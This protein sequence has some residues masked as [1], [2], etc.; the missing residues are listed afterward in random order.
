MVDGTV[1]GDSGDEGNGD[2]RDAGS[3]LACYRDRWRWDKVTWG[4]HCLNCL[5]TCPYRVY[6]RDGTILFEEPAAELPVIEAGVP[7]MNPLSCQKGSAWSR[8]LSGKDRILTPLRRVGER[9][10]GEWEEVSWDDALTEIAEAIVEAIDIEGPESV[11]F[12]ETVEGGLLTQAPVTRFAG[13]LG[14]VTLDANGLV[15]DFPTGQHIT[16][17]KFSCASTVDD[18]FHSDVILAW[19]SNPA[20]T[21]IPYF[22]YIPEARYSGAQV[23]AISPDYTPTAA[24]ADMHVP[25]RAGTDAAFALA[26]CKVVIDEG[27]ADL[28]FVRSQTDLAL[29]VETG[30]RT[31]LRGPEIDPN[32]PEDRFWF[33]DAAA[34][35][36]KAPRDTLKLDGLAPELEGRWKVGLSDGT[37]VEVTTVYELLRERL[38]GYEPEAATEMC[39]VAPDVIRDLARRIAKGRTKILEGFN[40]CKYY[41]GDL[42]ERSMCLLLAL[43]GNWGRP[44]TGIQGLA[45]A[46][47]DG[48]LIFA[49]K[50]RPGLE[51]TIGILDGVDGAME[52]FREQDPEASDEIVG[53]QLLQMAVVGGT[54]TPPVFFNYHHAG[55]DDAWNRMEWSDPSMEKTFGEYL[56]EA[57]SRGWW[58]GLTRPGSDTDPQVFFAVGT[59]PLRRARGGRNKVLETLWPKLEMIVTVDF[60]MSTTALHSDIILPV[61]MQYERP[62]VQ[63]AITH[64]FRLGFSDKAVDPPGEAKTEWEI[65][66]LLAEKVTEAAAAAGLDEY[67]DGR[68]RTRTL[69]DLRSRFTMNGAFEKEPAVLDEW[70]R[71]SG[72]AGT[73]PFGTSLDRLREAGSVRYSGLGKFAPG[74]SVAADVD[75][76]KVLTAFGWH[77]DDGVVYPTLTRRAQFYVDHAWFLDGDEALPRHK[78]PPSMG[79]DH[80]FVLTSGHSR[81]TVH[82]ISMGNDVLLETHRG[83]PLVVVNDA[84]AAT[85]GIADGDEVRVHNDHGEFRAAAKTSPRIRPDQIVLY[86]GFEPHMFPDWQGGNDVEPGMVKWLH[87]VGRYGHLRYLPFGWQPVPSDRAVR[88][89]LCSMSAAKGTPDA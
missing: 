48:F 32:E 13:L 38:R 86:N 61:A 42:M 22:H 31:F 26:M 80:P 84:Q 63:Y 89:S 53:T 47:L 66:Q 69:D 39:G 43:T 24:L 3:T 50:N 2:A 34:G 37:E 85:L 51:E 23:V 55:Y 29:L 81:W 1:D 40:A 73:L 88:V 41:H 72:E 87:L 14:A 5:G 54:S 57:V 15:N 83:G 71:D 10:G 25:I 27:L 12:E 21:S 82:S 67:L 52:S 70:L 17:G 20:Y 9:G 45:L 28:D 35:L 65:F 7:D 58:G 76:A 8:Q 6:T 79:G 4:T 30:T 74:L 33:W 46:G 56:G 59:N 64:T 44:G 60:R 36:T 75:P 16:F 19:H 68:R 49:M 11:V 78:E 77:V 18:T 62:N